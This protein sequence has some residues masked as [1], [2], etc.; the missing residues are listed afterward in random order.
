MSDLLTTDFLTGLKKPL[1]APKKKGKEIQEKESKTTSSKLSA[2]S[3]P[4]KSWYEAVVENEATS[5]RQQAPL[6]TSFDISEKIKEIQLWVV[7]LAQSP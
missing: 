7:G 1:M 2:N 3:K 6:Q 5:S 4:I